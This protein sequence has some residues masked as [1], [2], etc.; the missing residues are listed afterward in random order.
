MN[1]QMLALDIIESLRDG[2]PPKRGLGRYTVGYEDLIE[3]IKTNCLARISR[4]GAIR[5]VSGKLG[6]GKSHLFRLIRELALE[7]ECLVSNVELNVADTPF[8]QF[9]R[10][11][12]SI[13]G[14]I[15]TPSM[16]REGQDDE[17]FSFERVL[18]EALN[19][20]I[21]GN[22]GN[23]EVT[24]IT[25][26][27]YM[28]ALEGLQ[29]DRKIDFN[30]KKIVQGYW[31]TF[32]SGAAHPTELES[33]RG[34]ALQWFQG[35][36]DKATFKDRFKVTTMVTKNKAQAM[37]KSLAGFIRLAGYA[38]L[39][40]LFDE[41]A[42]PY[43]L[44]TKMERKHAYNN[45]FILINNIQDL[46]GLFLIYATTPDFF[47]HREY[48]V[49]R[50]KALASRISEPK[51]DPPRALQ[52]TWNLEA[53]PPEIDQYKEASRK[54]RSLYLEAYSNSKAE[55]PS[56]EETDRCVEE[57]WQ[58]HADEEGVSFWRVMVKALVRYLDACNE[59]KPRK[60]EEVMAEVME[61]IR[62]GD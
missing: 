49:I 35:E 10:V 44:M 4:R 40:I 53:V 36:G 20:L 17:A 7:N 54:I 19:Y 14:K 42:R 12:A 38:G 34:E 25:N 52:K 47:N 62:E 56:E 16:Y 51:G 13:V 30:F 6:S 37:L 61:E 23:D 18:K 28:Q 45:L 55:F 32:V 39:V 24:T 2:L 46:E 1:D 21:T 11:F 50:D 48:G 9:E 29:R 41:G 58:K 33:T 8:N 5:F 31:K 26:P 43:E 27:Q 57:I 60:I 3:G 22:K 59:G 15:Y